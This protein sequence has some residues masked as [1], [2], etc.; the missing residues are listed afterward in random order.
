MTQPGETDDFAVSDHV[1]VINSYLGKKKLNYV[2]VNNG[3]ITPKIIEKYSV[4]E[5]KDPVV[6]DRENIDPET[7]L[8]ECDLIDTKTGQILHDVLKLG[9]N[10]FSCLL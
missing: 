3:K 9:F 5:Q 7:K 6:I 2:I 10:I 8:I 1:N 4:L